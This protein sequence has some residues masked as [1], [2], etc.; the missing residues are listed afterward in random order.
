MVDQPD[1]LTHPALLACIR[2]SCG[3]T[4]ERTADHLVSLAPE[5]NAETVYGSSAVSIRIS[6]LGRSESGRL[7]LFV[8]SKAGTFYVNW[9]DRWTNAG[10]PAELATEYEQK[11]KDILQVKTVWYHPTAYQQAVPLDLLA[12]RLNEVTRIVTAAADQLRN[13][14]WPRT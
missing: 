2:Q 4:A 13:A 14:L 9:L 12:P 5:L 6:A 10:A 11:L 8:V 7:T 3:A 1:D